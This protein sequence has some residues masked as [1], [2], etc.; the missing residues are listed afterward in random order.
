MKTS[1]LKNTAA[2]S[3]LLIILFNFYLLLSNS[4]ASSQLVKSVDAVGITVADLDRSVEF[5]SRVL[6]FEK[7]GDVEVYGDAY[8]QLQAVFGARLRVAR[9]KL[10]D[11]TFEL[12]QYLAPEGRPIPADWRSNDHSFQ[13]IAIVVSDIDKAYRHLRAHGIRH[14]STAPQTIPAD[15]PAAAGIRAFYFKD[16]DGHQRSRSSRCSPTRS[17]LAMIVSAGFTAALLGKKLASTT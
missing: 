8:E 1:K 7:V 5:F 16:P 2:R 11:E 13:H 9:M 17:A 3:G 10:G 14:A 6:G 12:T 4:A 15:N